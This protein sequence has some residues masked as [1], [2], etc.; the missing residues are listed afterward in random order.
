MADGERTVAVRTPE[1]AVVDVIGVEKVCGTVIAAGRG[2]PPGTAVAAGTGGAIGITDRL[3]IAPRTDGG[4]ATTIGGGKKGRRGRQR[5]MV[6]RR[7]ENCDMMNQ[8]MLFIH[9]V[10]M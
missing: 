4:M 5:T 3:R 10:I 6:S 7:R 2:A 8:I 1:N 9:Q